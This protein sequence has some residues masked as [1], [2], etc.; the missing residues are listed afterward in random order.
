MHA[1]IVTRTKRENETY[2]DEF[3]TTNQL[4]NVIHRANYLVLCSERISETEQIID[5][6]RI[7]ELP[8]N[9]YIINIARGNLIDEEALIKTLQHELLSGAS[10]D[11]TEIEPLDAQSLLW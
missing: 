1:I 7:Q 8:H 11:V 4:D 6:K 3:Y 10:L 9:A 5:K 2:V